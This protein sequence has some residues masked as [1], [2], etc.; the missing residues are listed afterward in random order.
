MMPRK[1]S[2]EE[3]VRDIR[4]ATRKYRPPEKRI[5]LYSKACA[6]KRV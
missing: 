6:V 1:P 4:R 2:A 5:V 3:T